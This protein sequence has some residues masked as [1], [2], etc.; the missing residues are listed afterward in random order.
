MKRALAAIFVV[1]MTSHAYAC[2]RA[3][4]LLTKL[5][6]GSFSTYVQGDATVRELGPLTRAHD[7]VCVYGL[8]LVMPDQHGATRLLVTNSAGVLRATYL[9]TLADFIGLKGTT[10]LVRNA[11]GQTEAIEL[12]DGELPAKVFFDGELSDLFLPN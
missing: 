5:R 2:E 8:T 1:L 11:R 10:V 4:E 9:L 12:G 6:S 3:G 7:S